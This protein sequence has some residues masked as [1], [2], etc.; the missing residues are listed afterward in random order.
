MIHDD[1]HV[2]AAAGPVRD[3]TTLAATVLLLAELGVPGWASVEMTAREAGER[4]NG[5]HACQACPM[6]LGCGCSVPLAGRG[7]CPHGGYDLIHD[8]M[9]RMEGRRH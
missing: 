2:A 4:Y 3:R 7:I 9:A 5:Y 1:G 8:A 6:M